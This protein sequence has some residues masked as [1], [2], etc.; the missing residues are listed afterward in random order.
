MKKY[1]IGIDGGG[2]KTDFYLCDTAYNVQKTITLKGCNP[3][4]I[5]MDET[6]KIIKNGVDML[7]MLCI[8][9]CEISMFAGIAGGIT[10]N[11]REIL[12]RFLSYEYPDIAS[13]CGSDA[14]NALEIGLCGNDGIAVICGTGSVLFTQKNNVLHRLGGY[15]YL[16]NELGSGYSFGNAA[17]LAALYHEQHL[18]NHPEI[19]G[20]VQARLGKSAL[21][22]LNGIYVKGKHFIASFSDI[23]FDAY[24]SGDE[25]AALVIE[26]N[27]E[28]IANLIICAAK[29]H[30][31]PQNVALIG[32]I[33]RHQPI[34]AKAI[35]M[36]GLENFNFNIIT[37]PPAM[38]AIRKAE[39][40]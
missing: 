35:K 15:G 26:K 10:G 40:L 6:L 27:S 33:F 13:D 3:N 34:F 30:N 36:H 14:E 31:P 18:E 20:A 19:A 7:R 28:Y 8:K 16:F 9:P 24:Q 1:L 29:E 37:A 2:T 11:N 22:A 39:K 32:G 25:Y 4:D 5:G 12:K 23:L 17:I 38:G 21:E